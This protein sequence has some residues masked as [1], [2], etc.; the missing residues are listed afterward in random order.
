MCNNKN[1]ACTA[2]CL[3]KFHAQ[4]RKQVTHIKV[5][6]PDYPL[7]HAQV[8][9][10]STNSFMC[11]YSNQCPK[12]TQ[13]L[14]VSTYHIAMYV[15]VFFPFLLSPAPPLQHNPKSAPPA[16]HKMELCL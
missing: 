10:A 4:S 16:V 11:N 6:F 3:A 8:V 15:C 9:Y 14:H 2:M 13:E 1:N 7:V 5:P 12:L